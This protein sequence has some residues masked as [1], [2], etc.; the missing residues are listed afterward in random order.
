MLPEQS[1]N[2]LNVN[3]VEQPSLTYRLDIEKGTISGRVDGLEAVLQAVNKI[4][5]TER[6]SSVIYS[7]RYGTEL[8][9]L[10]GKD[11]AYVTA[12]L[13]KRITEA[14]LEDDRVLGV[15]GF[16]ITELPDNSL[17]V[18]FVVNTTVG[19]ATMNTEVQ[20]Q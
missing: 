5:V 8:E 14:L 1:N 10:L 17:S 18:S 9:S 12:V 13:E 7:A 4:L 15:S 2:V 3:I 16:E 6:Y 19:S 11:V 20:I